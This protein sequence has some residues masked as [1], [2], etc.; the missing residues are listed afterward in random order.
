M[1][2]SLRWV[3]DHLKVDWKKINVK[4][5]VEKFN[6]AVAEIEDFH[7]Y[8]C[9]L[10]SLALAKV[11]P[12]GELDCP[13]F[14]TKPVLPA[15][16]DLRQGSWYLIKKQGKQYVW[17]TP[18]DFGYPKEALLPAF[19][20]SDKDA[21][22]G[23]WK[24]KVE[25]KDIILDVD[26][27]SIT[28]RPDLWSHRGFARELA[29]LLDVALL[30][31]SAFLKKIP[32][33]QSDK[34]F[35]AT[36][37]IPFSVSRGTAACKRFAALYMD[38]VSYHPSSLPM[39]TRLLRLE[40]RAIDLFV[41]ATNYV[42]LDVGQPL[43]AFDAQKITTQVLEP[44]LAG[45]GDE[46][47]LLDGTQL[48]LTKDDL[49]ITDGKRP[50]AL[51][52]IK[53]GASTGVTADTTSIILESAN[54]D[55]GVVRLT[56]ARHK[57]RTEGSARFEKSLDPNQNIIGIMRFVK[58]LEDADAQIT[59][60]PKIVSLGAPAQ[61]PTIKVAHQFIE[62]RLGTE[63]KKDFVSK[64]L[65]KI[66]FEV[67]E[68]KGTYTIVVPTYRATK[69]ISIP[70]D[71]VEEVGRYLGYTSIPAVMPHI[72]AAPVKDSTFQKIEYIKQQLAFGAHMHEVNNYAFFDNTFLHQ[73]NWKLTRPVTLANPISEDRTVL[74]TCLIPG[75]LQNI[76]ENKLAKD[77][78]RFFEWGRVWCTNIKD[79]QKVDEHH[80]LGGIFYKRKGEVDFY[81]AKA[82]VDLML[83]LLGITV[84][85]RKKE[86]PQ[87]WASLH[88]TADLFCAGKNIGTAGKIRRSK[89]AAIG[90][91]D[92]FAFE[93]FGDFLIE[94]CQPEKKFK[95]LPKYQ[96]TSLDVS[97]MVPLS[98]EV[99][100]LEQAL[101]K[102]DKRIFAVA[103]KDVFIK[104]D[105]KNKK[106]ITLRLFV[107]DASRTL[108]K[109]D[110]E[111]VQMAVEQTMKQ[112]GA[113][114]R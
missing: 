23:A 7:E 109:E 55:A 75:L 83:S 24:K 51:A 95:E 26:N 12:S 53:G 93:L 69:D 85:W 5:L 101:A 87:Q 60:T 35:K 44:K 103:L 100:T 38:E 84:E 114:V 91:G 78:L 81:Q 19:A 36:K 1:K 99:A 47:E 92:A 13:E 21:K 102:V 25:D 70:E 27:K 32:V 89:I 59:Y 113:D 37:E 77:D 11:S 40:N 58:L 74:A 28:H 71:I 107:R 54:F 97:V 86:N 80:I 16:D 62:D 57:L 98:T 17:A 30:P 64:T 41:D 8:S 14:K 67:K 4:K 61:S 18:S 45:K 65:S 104:E 52:G 42:M 9:D 68:A 15:R 10:A 82:D 48:V 34:T 106:S 46:L 56:A 3:C 49:V 22:S 31:E 33:L 108:T 73:I 76:E 110:L 96:A 111:K 2:L 43:H 105:W 66:G 112:Y 88:Q 20:C 29:A 6:T 79:T 94:Y 90:G 63:I 39:A 50:L 72:K